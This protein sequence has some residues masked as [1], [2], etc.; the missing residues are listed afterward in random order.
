[1]KTNLIVTNPVPQKAPQRAVRAVHYFLESKNGEKLALIQS[2]RA[3]CSRLIRREALQ[4][5]GSSGGQGQRSRPAS[6]SQQTSQ[7]RQP[8]RAPN[9]LGGLPRASLR[10]P[11][12]VIAGAVAIQRAAGTYAAE[13]SGQSKTPFLHIPFATPTVGSLPARR[14]GPLTRS[15]TRTRP[16]TTLAPLSRNSVDKQCEIKRMS[17]FIQCRRT[18]VR[19]GRANGDEMKIRA[20]CYGTAM[21]RYSE[22]LVGGG[23]HAIRTPLYGGD[24]YRGGRDD[25]IRSTSNYTCFRQW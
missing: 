17:D 4:W 2:S 13:V 11:L 18:T 25:I 3:T 7:S 12:P 23:I 10:T 20:I 24:N 15:Q 9:T 19:Y 22:C 16:A 21:E 5:T 6:P 8:P 14:G 1:M